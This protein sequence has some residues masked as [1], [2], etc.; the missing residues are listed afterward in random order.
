MVSADLC[1]SLA[2]VTRRLCCTLV[3]PQALVHSCLVVPDKNLG[4]RPIGICETAR[5]II[6]KAILKVV[7][8]DVMEAAGTVQL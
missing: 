7:G 5:R 6:T 4:V 8:D 3:D 2:G 1:H